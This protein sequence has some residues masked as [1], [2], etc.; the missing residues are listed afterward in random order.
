MCTYATSNI[1]M[2]GKT[3]KDKTGK[4]VAFMER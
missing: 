3:K 1:I 2:G 4:C